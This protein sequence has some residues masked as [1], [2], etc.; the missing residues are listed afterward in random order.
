M[1]DLKARFEE[2]EH[3]VGLRRDYARRM[4]SDSGLIL[5][6]GFVERETPKHKPSSTA[7]DILGEVNAGNYLAR[8]TL[9]AVQAT[10]GWYEGE[11]AM[12]ANEGANPSEG[13]LNITFRPGNREMSIRSNI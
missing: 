9:E 11:R 7:C 4:H 8:R 6:G 2:D 5:S 10:E 3:E 12:S 13:P 1:K